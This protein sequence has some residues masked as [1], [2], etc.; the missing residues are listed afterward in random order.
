MLNIVGNK[1][2]TRVKMMWLYYDSNKF[3]QWSITQTM[4]KKCTCV[5]IG[6]NLVYCRF[7]NE[8]HIQILPSVSI[9][10]YET[11]S[12]EECIF[13]VSMTIVWLSSTYWYWRRKST[14]KKKN[15]FCSYFEKFEIKSLN[16]TSYLK[17]WNAKVRTALYK[18]PNSYLFS[19]FLKWLRK[20]LS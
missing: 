2:T 7:M 3:E 15:M 16:K 14:C 13:A 9:L 5:R 12:L 17:F 18:V 1:K 19:C 10:L 4:T 20:T 6:L 8:I 11:I